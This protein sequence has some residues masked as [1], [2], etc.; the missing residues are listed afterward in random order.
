[1]NHNDESRTIDS[2]T[3]AFWSEFEAYNQG[4]S[5]EAP[6]LWASVMN[7]ARK[8][9]YVDLTKISDRAILNCSLSDTLP[10]PYG[11]CTSVLPCS[12]PSS[13]SS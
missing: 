9:L 13:S 12:A 3:T 4:T 1:M 6:R 7:S 11:S 2:W 10:L 5:K 8:Y